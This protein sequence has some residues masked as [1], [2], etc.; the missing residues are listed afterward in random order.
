MAK[1]VDGGS[2]FRGKSAK[3]SN[4]AGKSRKAQR[5]KPAPAES[6]PAEA[7]RPSKKAKATAAPKKAKRAR[8]EAASEESLE[9]SVAPPEEE[10]HAEASLRAEVEAAAEGEFPD[11]ELPPPPAQPE[12]EEEEEAALAL[13][14]DEEEER[15]EPEPPRDTFEPE[16]A[17]AGSIGSEPMPFAAK[18]MGALVLARTVVDQGL[19]T[20][21]LGKLFGA[22]R[23]IVK[24]VSS[25]LGASGSREV[26]AYGKDPELAES[27][28][29]I[30][31]FLYERYWRVTAEGAQMLPNGP[32]IVVA[33]HSGALPF[34]G[35]VLSHAISRERPELP[36]ARWLV[37]DQI[38]YAPFVGTLF[39][40]LG[41]V[42]ACPEN[43]LRLVSEH[44][45]VIV[46]PEGAQGTGKS[47][48][49]RY[50]LKRLGRGGFAK[51][52]VRAG[53]PIVPVAVVGAEEALP[54]LGKLPGRA[55]GLPELPITPGPLP[56]KWSIRFGEPIET[57]SLGW[58]ASDDPKTIQRIV[59]QTRESIEGMLQALL[60]E[61]RSVFGG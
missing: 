7:A 24:A 11:E 55:L 4:G 52:A 15:I 27:L 32:A 45:P 46:F 29:P 41:A 43:L 17:H 53:V 19:R 51:L 10:S 25:G 61:R 14:L 48:R 2:S 33:N 30:A 9:P 38:F 56:A 8:A 1:G 3:T 22:A 16:P 39:N 28:S 12:P 59:E 34:D 60:K 6:P 23:G 36:E 42:R 57:Q 54:M 44:R 37:E 18:A 47:F 5:A 21:G 40:R 49:E 31:R 26:D 58:A 20:G 50:Q 13:G 35:P